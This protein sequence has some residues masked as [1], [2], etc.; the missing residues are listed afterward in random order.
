MV[1]TTIITTPIETGTSTPGGSFLTKEDLDVY[2][3]EIQRKSSVEVLDLK[4]LYNQRVA[5]KPYP[6][7]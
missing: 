6:K 7:D 2:Q 3:K 5:T 1:H 4:L